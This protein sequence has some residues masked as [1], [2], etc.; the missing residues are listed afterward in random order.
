MPKYM[1]TGSVSPNVIYRLYIKMD[2]IRL[3]SDILYV[4]VF[5]CLNNSL[6]ISYLII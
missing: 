6:L 2:N 4:Q 3:L 1:L 5:I